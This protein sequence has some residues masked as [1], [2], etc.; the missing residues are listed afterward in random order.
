MK[1]NENF[2][3]QACALKTHY[4]LQIKL[5]ATLLVVNFIYELCILCY[6]DDYIVNKILLL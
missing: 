4:L 5:G 1:T 2:S 3:D 6:V